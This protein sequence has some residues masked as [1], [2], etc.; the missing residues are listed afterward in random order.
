[1]KG[2]VFLLYGLPRFLARLG[3]KGLG[4]KGG[5]KDTVGPLQ[6]LH[7]HKGTDISSA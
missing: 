1:M 7:L 4:G 2:M 5:R 6:P 3:P